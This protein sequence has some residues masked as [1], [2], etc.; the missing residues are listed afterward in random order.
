M[1]SNSRWPNSGFQPHCW[2]EYD[3]TGGKRFDASSGVIAELQNQDTRQ[4]ELP[5]IIGGNS[6]KPQSI[7]LFE[8]QTAESMNPF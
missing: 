8:R 1:F 5:Y 2:R 3:N 7:C 4:L 6:R